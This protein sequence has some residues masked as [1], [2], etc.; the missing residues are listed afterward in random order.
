M[1]L[2]I[3]LL[4]VWLGLAGCAQMSKVNFPP[5]GLNTE[6]VHLI[7]PPRVPLNGKDLPADAKLVLATLIHQI[8]LYPGLP[9][10]ITFNSSGRHELYDNRLDYSAF[11]IRHIDISTYEAFEKN[12][13]RLDGIIHF[14]DHLTRRTSVHYSAYY[15]VSNKQV[16]VEESSI[17]P[18]QPVYPRVEV[19]YIPEDIFV[20]AT[21]DILTDFNSLYLFALQNAIN[22]EPTTTERKEREQWEKMS[23]FEKVRKPRLITSNRYVILAFSLDRIL[24]NGY[25]NIN[26]STSSSSCPT[27]SHESLKILDDSGWK[28]GLIGAELAIDDWNSEVFVNVGYGPGGDFRLFSGYPMLVGSFN[29]TKN[30]PAVSDPDYIAGPLEQGLRFLNPSQRD[31]ARLIQRRLAEHGFYRM[32]IDGLFGPGSLSALQAFR[33]NKRLGDN[34]NWDIT[35]QMELFA[36]SEL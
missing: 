10:Q 13:F 12:H 5:I 6:P 30:Y 3:L 19:F 31:D 8:Y 16:V 33:K 35:T 27:S 20:S 1:R 23:L 18:I 29:T 9:D 22:M 11:L 14:E 24:G 17:S 2:I 4:V 15:R 7:I 34:S 32:E 26:F 28:I 21:S 25:L 36:G